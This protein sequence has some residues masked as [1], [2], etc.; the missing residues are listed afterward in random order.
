MAWA[1]WEHVHHER[2]EIVKV[3]ADRLEADAEAGFLQL[4]YDRAEKNAIERN[5]HGGFTVER[6]NLDNDPIARF[7][8]SQCKG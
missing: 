3:F 4:A 1:V 2:H 8:R 7:V 5:R 6:L